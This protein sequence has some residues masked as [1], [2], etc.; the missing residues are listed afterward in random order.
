[1]V[2]I[3]ISESHWKLSHI[4]P[5]A[6]KYA[7][8]KAYITSVQI[9][10]ELKPKFCKAC[11]KAK[12]AQQPFPKELE[13]HASKYRE[14]VHW[15]LWG[16]AAAQSTSRNWNMAACIDVVSPRSGLR[17]VFNRTGPRINRTRPVL[18]LAVS[19]FNFGF[20]LGLQAVQDG[21]N[22]GLLPN[23]VN[24]LVLCLSWMHAFIIHPCHPLVLC[25]TISTLYM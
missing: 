2:K 12:V 3:T 25:Y 6:I 21:L 20:G 8:T 4:T 11:A 15:D 16:P 19:Q 22:H 17:R 7:I 14:C 24:Q 9:D 23:L 13:T 1:M 10:P 5:V 18:Y